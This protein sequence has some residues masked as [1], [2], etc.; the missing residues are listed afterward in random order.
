MTLTEKI[1]VRRQWTTVVRGKWSSYQSQGNRAPNANPKR[2]LQAL[3]PTASSYQRLQG[4]TN[5]VKHW[6]KQHFSYTE[7]RARSAS[8]AGIDPLQLAGLSQQV[9]QGNCAH[10]H[11]SHATVE[12]APSP[13]WGGQINS[14]VGQVPY[15][16]RTSSKAKRAPHW[17]WNR[18]V[19]PSKVVSPAHAVWAL[20]PG[21]EVFQTQGPFLCSWM[22]AGKMRSQDRLSQQIS[23][24]C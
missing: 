6:M 23:F 16:W 2:R 11:T 17:A 7:D 14:G 22:G 8:I 12:G 5:A 18:K 10:V 13:P 4:E 21:K 3:L 9:T 15:D 19:F 20:S 1:E 24:K